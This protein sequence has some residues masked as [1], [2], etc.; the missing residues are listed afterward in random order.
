MEAYEPVQCRVC[1]GELDQIG[2]SRYKC[3]YC[4]ET[5]NELLYERGQ[6]TL[7][8]NVYIKV[9]DKNIK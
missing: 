5:I 3:R 7:A 2:D 6:N 4:V 1:G 9:N 8:N